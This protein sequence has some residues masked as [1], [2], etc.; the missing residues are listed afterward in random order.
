MAS[1]SRL[2]VKGPNAVGDIKK[3]LES[4]AVSVGVHR[5]AGKH[6][7]SE[8][9]LTVAQIF[10]YNEF[11]TDSIPERPTLRPTLAKERVKYQYNMAKIA[12][13]AMKDEGYD[14]RQAMGR[15]GQQVQ[16]DVQKAIRDLSDPP[17]APETIKRKGSSSPL[18][19]TGQMLSSIRWEYAP[20]PKKKGLFDRIKEFFK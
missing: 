11:G 12:A 3:K 1:R 19:D 14:I 17:N 16:G 13:K 2:I 9:G 20:P 6:K 15:L 7:K 4:S 5:D 18:I 10:S 8:D